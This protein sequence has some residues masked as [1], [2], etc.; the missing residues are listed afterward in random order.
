MD[1]ASR[2]QSGRGVI[3]QTEENA[4]LRDADY[5]EAVEIGCYPVAKIRQLFS[6]RHQS[7]LS[8]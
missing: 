1:F 7:H 5:V 8:R 4:G 2:C 6:E 3:V